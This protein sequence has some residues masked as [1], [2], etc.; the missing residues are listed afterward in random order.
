VV[1]GGSQWY[2]AAVGFDGTKMW[3]SANG[4]PKTTQSI[5]GFG[6]A[7]NIFHMGGTGAYDGFDGWLAGAGFWHRTLAD[8]DIAH[9][10]NLGNGIAGNGPPI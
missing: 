1:T 4:A 3:V 5:N 2:F 6:A 9:M 10:F 7:P 8:V